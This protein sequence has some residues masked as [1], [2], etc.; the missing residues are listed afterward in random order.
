[1]TTTVF[2]HPAATCIWT[3]APGYHELM[4]GAWVRP[5]D[6]G[7]EIVVL[8]AADSDGGIPA[9][10]SGTVTTLTMLSADRWLADADLLRALAARGVLTMLVVGSE[11]PALLHVEHRVAE[12]GCG[13]RPEQWVTLGLD[14]EL[15]ADHDFDG[16]AA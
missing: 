4:T 9:L 13:V 5:A 16:Q 11:H 14:L 7:F 12:L 10:V 6:G 2:D 8:T 15:L 3:P 1:V